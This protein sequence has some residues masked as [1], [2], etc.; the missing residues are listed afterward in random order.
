MGQKDRSQVWGPVTVRLLPGD[1]RLLKASARPRLLP[2]C[3]RDNRHL[4]QPRPTR[5]R[6][7]Q[8]WATTWDRLLCLATEV[9]PRIRRV[10]GRLC[11][12]NS[13][14]EPAVACDRGAQHGRDQARSNGASRDEATARQRLPNGKSDQVA[15]CIILSKG[16]VPGVARR[17]AWAVVNAFR[18]PSFSLPPSCFPCRRVRV[19]VNGE[20]AAT[21][22]TANAL[23]LR[24]LCA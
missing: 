16:H 15:H 20:V 18:A 1:T 22:G 7:G 8:N 11:E 4:Q 3:P 19:I 10:S 13:R 5:C 9:C 14:V 6:T 23:S 2:A 12:F 24:G 21:V 17:Y